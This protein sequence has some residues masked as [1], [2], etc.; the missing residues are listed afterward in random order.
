MTLQRPDTIPA[1]ATSEQTMVCY[2]H[3]KTET[4]VACSSCGRPIC[5]ECMVFAAVGIKCPDCAGQPIG[6]KKATKRAHSATISSTSGLV[7]KILIAINVGA[8]LL[9]AGQG[10]VRY[11]VDSEAFERGALAGAFLAEGE[12]WRMITTGFLHIGPL[13]L[14]MNM[15]MLWWFGS[16]LE[17]LLG[18]WR[19]L[20]IYGISIL[21]GSAGALLL[22]PF[23]Y[24]VGASSGVFGVLGAGLVLERRGINVFGGA[25]LI[26]V[27]L[28]LALSVALEN[29]SLGAHV[30]GLVGG[31]LAV[32]ALSNF[33]RAHAA[34][35]RI[36]L[37]GGVGLAGIVVASV[38]IAYARVHGYA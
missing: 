24:T 1:V 6:I 38:V 20:A 16:S 33:G 4:A 26:V 37:I 28:N 23:D 11:G 30:G 15:L 35:A 32:L 36:G 19:F 18:R 27:L 2:R 31:A 3:P 14:A 22:E 12:W 17:A 34:Y 10:D 5:T 13:H 9:Q 25:A 7:V 29:I 8:F 21:A